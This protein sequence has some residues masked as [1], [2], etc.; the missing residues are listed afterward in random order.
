[1]RRHGDFLELASP[2]NMCITPQ[3]D[4]LA[5]EYTRSLLCE[6]GYQLRYRRWPALGAAE[7]TIILVNGMMS[8]SGWFL[9]L[10]YLLTGLRLNVVGAD[11]R[12]TGLNDGN[13]GDAPSRQALVSDLRRIIESEDCG[14]PIYLVGW[15]WGAVLAVNTALEPSPKLSGLVFL[16]PGLFPSA[17]VKRRVREEMTKSLDFEPDSPCLNSPLAPEMFSGQENF[18][19]FIRHD[20]L[21]QRVFTPRFFRIAGEM[22]LIANARLSQLPQPTL[23]LMAAKDETADNQQTV[24]AFSRLPRTLVTTDSLNCQHGM[25]FEAPHEIVMRILHWLQCESLVLSI[26]DFRHDDEQHLRS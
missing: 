14:L 6:D 8:H 26:K 5:P 16:A 20:E 22:S 4:L 13:R 12:G 25:Q 17:E 24:K 11:R 7:G 18:R 2:L 23:L 19:N 15:S 3:S 21:T 1:V 10:A 9:E